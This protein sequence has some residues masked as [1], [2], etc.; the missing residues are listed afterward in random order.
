MAVVKDWTLAAAE[1]IYHG[2]EHGEH[3]D[4]D[5]DII[6]AVIGKHSP[7][8]EGVAYMEVP[9]C[10][11]CAHWDIEHK[12]HWDAHECKFLSQDFCCS[13]RI[14]QPDPA[15]PHDPC[16]SVYLPPEFNGGATGGGSVETRPDFGC[17]E[18]KAP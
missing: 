18:W 15:T 14:V 13:G 16:S 9:R 5:P 3:L 4:T 11:T 6:A 8:K 10:Q 1:E 2:G 7:F 12:G 17:N